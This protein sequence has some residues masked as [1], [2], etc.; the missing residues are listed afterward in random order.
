IWGSG[1]PEAGR[2]QAREEVFGFCGA[3][4]LLRRAALEDVGAFEESFFMYYE[5][6]DLSWRMRL[7]GWRIL[8]EPGAVVEHAHAASTGEW[9]PFFTF[10]VDRNRVLTLL[11]C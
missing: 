1:E 5:D 8:Y 9:S 6:L 10:H 4:A 7:R 11:R 3:A 2:Y